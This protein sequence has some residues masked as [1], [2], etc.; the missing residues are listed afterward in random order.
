MQDLVVSEAHLWQ[1]DADLR[2]A[3][4]RSQ[5]QSSVGDDCRAVFNDDRPSASTCSNCTT[6]WVPVRDVRTAE[7]HDDVNSLTAN[8]LIPGDPSNTRTLYFP[9]FAW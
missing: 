1:I 4:D 3:H 2:L 5:F 9:W 6:I 7:I 8:T